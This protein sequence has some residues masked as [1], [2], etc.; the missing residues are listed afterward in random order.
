LSATTEAVEAWV[1]VGAGVFNDGRWQFDSA[2]QLIKLV[3]ALC[4]LAEA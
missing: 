4:Q 3:D 2:R 1:E